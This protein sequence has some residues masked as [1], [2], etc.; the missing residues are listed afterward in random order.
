MKQKSKIFIIAEAGVNHN[1]SLKLAKKLVDLACAAG[2]DAVKFQTFKTEE[3][4][5]LSAP[6]AEYQKRTVPGKSQYEMLKKLE[7]SQKDFVELFKYCKK[8]GIMFLSTPFDAQS[9]SFLH[10]LGMKIFKISSGELT[11]HPL[12][13][14]IATYGKPIILSTGMATLKEVGKAVKEAHKVANRRITLLHC[15]SNYPARPEDVNL[16]A[17]Q[18]LGRTFKVPAGYSD[19]TEGLIIPIAAAALGAAVI[20]K[21]FTLDK[22]LP[23]PDHQVS[24]SPAELKEMICSIRT[25][26]LAQ[27]DGVKKPTKEE[28]STRKLARKSIVARAYIE[29][30]NIIQPDMLAC[31]R[32]GHGLP[33]VYLDRV[34]GRKAKTA[35]SA[36]QLIRL[37]ML[38]P[39][40]R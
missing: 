23:G 20:E 24:L 5:T 29:R 38:E 8:K 30:S 40:K 35:I 11:N 31:K 39:V 27:G 3:L 21:H 2:A 7:L 16:R 33:P 17:M 13:R 1:G 28:A 25:V 4:V 14:Q 37:S 18:T 34:I 32:P 12:I 9:A 22:S 15:T 10:K 19:H 6:K 36:D 26:E